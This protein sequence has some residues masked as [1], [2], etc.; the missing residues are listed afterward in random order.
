MRNRLRERSLEDGCRREQGAP[1]DS[2]ECALS[3]PNVSIEGMSGRST[4]ELMA[5]QSEIY[6][7]R[8]GKSACSTPGQESYRGEQKRVSLC[9]PQ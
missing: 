3:V 2:D 9:Q 8:D 6:F 7:G 4:Q 5:S 1:Y